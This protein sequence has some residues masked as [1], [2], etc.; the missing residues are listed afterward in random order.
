M[1]ILLLGGT[2]FLGPHLV[3]IALKRGHTVTAFNRG[4]FSNDTDARM[5][6]ITGDRHHDLNKLSGRRWD[7]VIDN[8]GYL[9]K[10][11]ELSARALRESVEKYVFVSSVSAY[12]G[13]P[14]SDLDES[15][16]LAELTHEQ[17]M[18]AD[19]ID[20]TGDITAPALAEMYGPLKAA[21]E[22]TIQTEMPGRTLIIRPGLIVGPLDHTDRFTYWL[23]RIADG[24]E[25]LAPGEPSQNVQ[26]VDVRDVAGFIITAVESSLTG[27]FQVDGLPY[28]T[29]MGSML[30]TINNVTESNARFTWVDEQFIEREGIQPWND[31]PVYLPASFEDAAGFMSKN[32]GQ[33]LAAGLTLTPLETTVWD[34]FDWRRKQDHPLRAGITR[35][36]EAELLKKWHEL[37]D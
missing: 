22:K 26:F 33:A 21:C 1:K 25:V 31:L 5:E 32:I 6:V 4:R 7:A 23:M 35:E 10:S 37:S 11:V 18:R 15:N 9:P 8:C 14:K 36:R 24:G 13:F 28:E 29:T 30:E 34:T 17:E 16:P 27:A 3:D 2:R 12:A 20:L 19:Q